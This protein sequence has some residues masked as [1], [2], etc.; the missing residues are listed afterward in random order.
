MTYTPILPA[1]LTARNQGCLWRIEPDEKGRPT[2][3][4]YRP[5]GR[6]P[7][8]LA[9]VFR[10]RSDRHT[11]CMSGRVWDRGTNGRQLHSRRGGRD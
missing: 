3:V 1:E 7:C 9:T 2:K 11:W 4:P 8:L 10:I 6:T 5:D